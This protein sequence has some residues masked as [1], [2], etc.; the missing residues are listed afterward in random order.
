MSFPRSHP[1]AAASWDDNSTPPA[2]LPRKI[3]ISRAWRGGDEIH[4]HRLDAAVSLRTSAPLPGFLFPRH[5]RPRTANTTSGTS[6]SA[7]A[8]SI[9]RSTCTMPRW[10]ADQRIRPIRRRP[11]GSSPSCWPRT[12]EQFP[13]S[14]YKLAVSSPPYIHRARPCRVSSCRRERHW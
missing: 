3:V 9:G 2:T 10:T 11:P 1:A 13:R 7:G 14:S 4:G 12:T 8:P 5:T 6:S